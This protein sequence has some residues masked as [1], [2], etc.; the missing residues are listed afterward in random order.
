MTTNEPI[1]ITIKNDEEGMFGSESTDSVNVQESIDNFD[2]QIMKRLAEQFPGAEINLEY[3]PYSGA[4]IIVEGDD[5]DEIL[6][7]VTEIVGHVYN[8]ASFWSYRG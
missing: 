8:N 4:S 6:D 1:L 3:G 7:A 2:N 5:E